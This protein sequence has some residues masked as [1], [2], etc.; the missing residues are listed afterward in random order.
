MKSR[1]LLVTVALLIAGL[2]AEAAN[3]SNVFGHGCVIQAGKTVPVWGNA[4]PG[5]SISLQVRDLATKKPLKTY[6]AVADEYGR[7]QV[8]LDPMKP[9]MLLFWAL[10]APSGNKALASIHTGDVWVYVGRYL[11]RWGERQTPKLSFD[12]LTKEVRPY[13]DV[14]FVYSACAKND[15][16]QNSVYMSGETGRWR[17]VNAG[18]IFGGFVPGIGMNFA[19]SLAK[20]RKYPVAL[21]NAAD[22]YDSTIEEYLPAEAILKDPRLSKLSYAQNLK[23]RIPGTEENNKFNDETIAY[24]ERFLAQAESAHKAGDYVGLPL[25]MPRVPEELKTVAAKRYNAMIHPFAPMAVKG[26]IY[27]EPQ[28]NPHTKPEYDE[29]L[30]CLIATFRKTFNDPKLP[31]FLLQPPAG[32]TQ[33][34]GNA[35]RLATQKIA[36]DDPDTEIVVL[37]DFCKGNSYAPGS[38]RKIAARLFDQVQKS[39]YGVKLENK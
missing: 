17:S 19:L 39:V 16:P 10:T 12:D 29:E 30:K 14:F 34:G 33:P 38:T 18:W 22:L 3:F 4:E 25:D 7:W 11:F 26:V 21:I 5:E 13:Q 24:V 23:I 31:V 27:N 36:D 2:E 35:I 6:S 9:G 8:E 15:V 1:Y 32:G 37:D 28:S 20:D